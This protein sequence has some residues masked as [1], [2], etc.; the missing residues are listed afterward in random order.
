MWLPCMMQRQ[1]LQRAEKRKAQQANRANSKAA[2]TKAAE[3]QAVKDE[4][5]AIAAA[6]FAA[7]TAPAASSGAA[8]GAGS[9]GAPVEQQQPLSIKEQ[10]AAIAAAA[11]AAAPAAVDHA[12][13]VTAH[14]ELVICR[15][16]YMDHC[17]SNYVLARNLLKL[18]WQRM[19][20]FMHHCTCCC[21]HSCLSSHRLHCTGNGLQICH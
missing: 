7:M 21:F 1:K 20:G 10:A 11:F 13:Q 6:A 8:S 5:A 9:G 12:E 4:A 15:L 14:A 19:K 16:A 17:N 2:A 3:Q 18:L